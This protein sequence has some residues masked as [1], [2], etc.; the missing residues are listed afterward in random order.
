MIAATNRRNRRATARPR[1]RASRET[2]Q[3]KAP[4]IS[5]RGSY[6]CSCVLP[7]AWRNEGAVGV[8]YQLRAVE[9]E[10]TFRRIPVLISLFH[11]LFSIV[12]LAASA[13]T[14]FH[15]I[16][17]A[18]QLGS[19]TSSVVITVALLW[20]FTGVNLRQEVIVGE[21]VIK[22]IGISGRMSIIRIGDV[23]EVR[24][25]VVNAAS[26][27]TVKTKTG[28]TFKMMLS[29]EEAFGLRDELVKRSASDRVQQ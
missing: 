28:Q 4:V 21:E 3:S 19:A 2:T 24:V 9:S 10:K 6:A 27:I 7:S 26:G 14:V 23:S 11:L 12:F 16:E 29:E 13:L 22:W 25:S 8:L 1:R 15:A 5:L 20:Y 18:S 17:D